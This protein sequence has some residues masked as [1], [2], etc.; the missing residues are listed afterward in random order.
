MMAS[1]LIPCYNAERWIGQCIESAIEQT[2]PDKEIIIVD[3]GSTDRSLEIIKGFGGHIRWETGPNRGGNA[4]RNRLLEL[5]R[6]EWLQY[7]DADDYLLSDKIG[8]QMEVPAERSE[9][10]IIFSPVYWE[11]EVS[12]RRTL[13]EVPEPNDLWVLLARWQMPQTGGFLWRK[14]AIVDVGGWKPGQPCCQE[15][16]LLLRLMMAGRRFVYV[17][18]A[19]AVYRQWGEHTVCK[20]NRP[21]VHQQRLEIERRAEEWL[22]PRGQLTPERLDAINQSRFE[23]A[24]MVWQYDRGFAAS[25]V[26][27]IKASLPGFVPRGG[28]APSGYQRVFRLLGFR[29]AEHL[30]SLRRKFSHTSMRE[31]YHSN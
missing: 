10:D 7:L 27:T 19:G 16:E 8:P 29:M 24:R 3:D 25:V 22:R 15:N 23:V 31:S 5:A 14:Q 12:G 26:K 9:A 4:T 30:A 11:D 21:E 6:G 20:R 1:I 2:W 17:D 18:H 28:A 13:V